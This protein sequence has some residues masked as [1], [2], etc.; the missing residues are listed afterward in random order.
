M[1]GV[2]RMALDLYAHAVM[3]CR[4][5][6]RVLEIIL[7]RIGLHS[8]H[9][10]TVRQWVHRNG[11]HQL[12]QP[13]EKADD[14]VV[15]A[16]ITIGIGNIKCLAMV[17]VRMETI[18]SQKDMILSHNDVE[19]LGVYPTM[20][21]TGEHFEKALTEVHNKIGGIRAVVIDEGPDVKKGV[22]LY[23]EN[24][25]EA[26]IIHDIKHKLSLVMKHNLENDPK[27][28]SYTTAITQTRRLLYQ[29]DL[30][31][32]KPPA[33][34]SKARYMNIAPSIEWPARILN[35]KRSGDLDSIPE[36]RYQ[37][38]F[39]WIEEYAKPLETWS[40][41]VGVVE[42]I[43]HETRT[44]GLSEAVYENLMIFF[45]E[46]PLNEQSRDIAAKSMEKVLEE[47]N[48]LDDEQ[49]LICST[50]VLESLFGKYKEVTGGMQGVTGN[51]LGIGVF[52]GNERTD[53]SVKNVM[54]GCSVKRAVKWV[55]EKVGDTIARVR[56]RLLPY[57]R[58]KF[59]K[60]EE[61]V[62]TC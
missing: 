62:F 58:T 35:A 13:V 50:E 48:K 44:H 49:T 26:K 56:R 7:S 6:A 2:V 38:F 20:K 27:W 51:V 11:C 34:R 21:A 15:L 17:G 33:K 52:V 43:C 5:I 36:E 32:L 10:T 12:E 19:L 47:V 25:P 40:S 57:K 59:D 60:V 16:D 23:Q 45:L 31:A 41:M 54:E 46:A 24:H 18:E 9:H 55:K 61:G 30:T 14:W 53:E 8:P 37:K 1:S 22:H 28:A 29:T 3:G 42:M 39:G 4:K